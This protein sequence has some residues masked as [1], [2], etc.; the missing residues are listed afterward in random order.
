MTDEEYIEIDDSLHVR[1]HLEEQIV[2][3]IIIDEDGAIDGKVTTSAFELEGKEQL[4][5][6]GEILTAFSDKIKE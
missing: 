6:I 4:K 1:L 5:R 3:I 2:M